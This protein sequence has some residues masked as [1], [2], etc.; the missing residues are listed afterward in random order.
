M[1]ILI[2]DAK[3][4]VISALR[5]VLEQNHGYSIIGEANN[6]ISLFSNISQH[7]PD[8]VILDV[9]LPGIKP[10][11]SHECKNLSILIKT[12]HAFCPSIYVIALSSLPHFKQNCLQAKVDAFAC[13]SDPP[14]RLL[15]IIERLKLL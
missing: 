11:W 5:L 2:S 15:K 3:D 8:V 1:K 6:I 12:L 9:D 10:G 7:C 14:E 13:K 4:E